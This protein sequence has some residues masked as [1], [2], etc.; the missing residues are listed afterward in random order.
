MDMGPKCCLC[1]YMENKTGCTVIKE[2]PPLKSVFSLEPLMSNS[3]P[4]LRSPDIVSGVAA[5][6]QLSAPTQIF[7]WRSEKNTVN[8]LTL[9]KGVKVIHGTSW[10]K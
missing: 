1:R 7:I 4:L 10:E 3:L 8:M 6:T 5:V 2:F 9:P